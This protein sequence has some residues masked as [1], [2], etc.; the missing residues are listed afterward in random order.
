M[1][2][3]PN[4]L[5]LLHLKCIFEGSALE[6]ERNEYGSR[7]SR[8][9]SQTP[10]QK[11]PR[12]GQCTHIVTPTSQKGNGGIC[13]YLNNTCE[14]VGEIIFIFFPAFSYGEAGQQKEWKEWKQYLRDRTQLVTVKEGFVYPGGQLS[15]WLRK[16]HEPPQ[17]AWSGTCN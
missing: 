14:H 12:P 13:R 11:P 7:D 10:S 5:F 1:L 16:S 8:M 9:N 2:E 6:E 17:V 4:K 3:A 15:S